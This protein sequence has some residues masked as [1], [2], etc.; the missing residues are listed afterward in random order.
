MAFQLLNKKVV[1]A[2]RVNAAR[3]MRFARILIASGKANDADLLA[4]E[5]TKRVSGAFSLGVLEAMGAD[6]NWSG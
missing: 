5:K 3:E 1:G 4:N 6:E 2:F